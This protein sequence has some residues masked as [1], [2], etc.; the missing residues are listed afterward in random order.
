MFFNRHVFVKAVSLSSRAP[1]G[2]VTS[3]TKAAALHNWTGAAVLTGVLVTN[4]SVFV[5][6]EKLVVGVLVGGVVTPCVAMASSVC[7]AEVYNGFNVEAASGVALPGKLHA[8]A[9]STNRASPNQYLCLLLNISTPPMYM[10]RIAQII[11]KGKDEDDMHMVPAL[12]GKWLPFLIWQPFSKS[13]LFTGMC[14]GRSPCPIADSL[15]QS[16][17]VRTSA[18]WWLP[19]DE[20]TIVALW[21]QNWLQ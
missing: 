15:V 4:A 7:A 21:S 8:S 2:T 16:S 5:G 13:Y 17:Q 18:G 3:R 6:T 9:G 12:I 14:N 11:I 1:S 19:L 20:E 10:H